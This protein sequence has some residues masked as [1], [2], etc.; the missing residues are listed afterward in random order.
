MQLIAACA[1]E[2]ARLNDSEFPSD[3][4]QLCRLRL[5]GSIRLAKDTTAPI[6]VIR[7]VSQ[8]IS[9]RLDWALAT[10]T[11]RGYATRNWHGFRTTEA[12]ASGELPF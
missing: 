12:D 1:S 11:A 6:R 4:Q 2:D 9:L 10:G 8:E 5:T 7:T 3:Q